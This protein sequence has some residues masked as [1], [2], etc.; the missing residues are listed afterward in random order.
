MRVKVNWNIGTIIDTNPSIA[1]TVDVYECDPDKINDGWI[2]QASPANMASHSFSIA[3][4]IRTPK[5]LL[6][7]ANKAQ[8][9]SLAQ[10]AVGV[11]YTLW[12]ANQRN[13]ILLIMLHGVGG[14]DENG[15]LR[16]LNTWAK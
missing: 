16:A 9:I 7:D 2:Y 6:A 1:D 11:H 13:A 3:D 10:S 14:L 5:G 8:I 4:F 12:T 15:N